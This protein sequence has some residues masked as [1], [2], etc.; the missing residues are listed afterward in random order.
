MNP[1]KA[2]LQPLNSA[3]Q[4]YVNNA[5]YPDPDHP[6]Q[7]LWD[8]LSIPDHLFAQGADFHCV[9]LASLG[10]L[11]AAAT[12]SLATSNPDFTLGEVLAINN[13]MD[14]AFTAAVESVTSQGAA[15]DFTDI[16]NASEG[17]DT[18]YDYLIEPW[19]TIWPVNIGNAK[20][21]ALNTAIQKCESE[22]LNLS[23]GESLDEWDLPVFRAGS[24]INAVRIAIVA[25]LA[26]AV[27]N[28]LF[29]TAAEIDPGAQTG[30]GNGKMAAITS[31][32]ETAFNAAEITV[33]TQGEE[34]N[35]FTVVK[36]RVDDMKAQCAELVAAWQAIWSQY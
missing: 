26:T 23:D 29:T 24:S 8:F 18:G 19:E 14:A 31:A 13:A 20:W 28:E 6:S 2:Q 1:T 17:E 7:S 34:Q 4:D 35:V 27:A 5:L 33:T 30:G 16:Q 25:E 32:F 15:F 12:A 9:P 21:Q 3:I 36:E 10:A 11:K 22:K